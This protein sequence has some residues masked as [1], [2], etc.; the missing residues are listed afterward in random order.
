[1]RTIVRTARCTAQSGSN[2]RSPAVQIRGLIDSGISTKI[3][4]LILPCLDKPRGILPEDIQ[5][6]L[7]AIL[8]SE[9]ERMT[10]RIEF[11]TRNRDAI[12]T[13]IE[14]A[15]EALAHRTPSTAA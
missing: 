9:Q 4:A 7:I 13:Y 1:M 2:G 12:S 10:Q 3:I 6:E 11:L 8:R 5:P 14:A 15:D